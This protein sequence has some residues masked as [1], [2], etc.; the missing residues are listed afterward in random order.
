MT[1]QVDL[2]RRSE[3]PEA[4]DAFSFEQ[5]SRFRAAGL[6][7]DF[8]LGC[9]RY[10]LFEKADGGGVSRI[11]SFGEGVHDADFHGRA[12]AEPGRPF[13]RVSAA[14]A[15]FMPESVRGNIASS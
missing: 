11:R 4:E 10:F 2:R 8:P 3:P 1:A 15:S 13:F 14:A 7:G 12:A 6:E 5:K 9:V